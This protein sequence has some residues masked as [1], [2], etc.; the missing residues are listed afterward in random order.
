MSFPDIHKPCSQFLD[1]FRRVLQNAMLAEM[2]I[3]INE[4]I[5]PKKR[6]YSQNGEFHGRDNL[7][8]LAQSF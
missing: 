8:I 4:G 7:G 3:S 2:H 5:S 6:S 1:A